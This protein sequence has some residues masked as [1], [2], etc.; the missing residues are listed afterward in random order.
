MKAWGGFSLPT[1]ECVFLSAEDWP[2]VKELKW[3]RRIQ[4]GITYVESTL[5]RDPITKKQ[6][7]I[8]LHRFLLGVTDRTIFVDHINRNG[9]DNRRENLRLATRAENNRNSRK[10]TIN[11]CKYKGVTW[12]HYN[13]KFVASITVA[14]KKKHLGSFKNQEEAA[15]AYDAAAKQFFGNFARGNFI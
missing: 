9:L 3:H 2:Q 1:G 15:K 10:R 14:G 13:Q 11:P 5:R 4:R 8:S 12:R 6:K 7:T